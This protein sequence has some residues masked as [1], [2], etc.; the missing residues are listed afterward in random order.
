MN[1]I[2]WEDGAVCYAGEAQWIAPLNY[3]LIEDSMTFDDFQLNEIRTGDFIPVDTEQKYNEVVEVFGLFGHE[4]NSQSGYDGLQNGAFS[5]LTIRKS[6]FSNVKI[7]YDCKRQLTYSQIIAIGKLKRMMNEREKRSNSDEFLQAVIEDASDAVK[8]M[9]PTLFD[10][11][12]HSAK[13]N[14]S[15]SKVNRDI[16]RN[17]TKNKSKQAYEILESLDYEY[18]LVK[19]KWFRKEWV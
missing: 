2:E 4:S 9:R 18:D 19:Q 3:G 11:S 1:N 16:E 8:R 17:Q 14:S 13:P 10:F 7:G 5:E 12:N 15:V 6:G